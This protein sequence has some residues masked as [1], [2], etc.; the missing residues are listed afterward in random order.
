MST[1]RFLS[2]QVSSFT[3]S[4][5]HD[6]IANDEW[7]GIYP[8]SVNWIIWFGAMLK[9]YQKLQP[10]SKWVPE[11]KDALQLIW[12]TLPEKTTDNVKDSRK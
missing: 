8:T 9:S 2:F 4:N 1:Y 11:F 3:K 10:K 7:P 12:F 5:C 6:F